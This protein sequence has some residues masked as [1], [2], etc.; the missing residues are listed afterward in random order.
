VRWTFERFRK[1]VS[2]DAGILSPKFIAPL[3]RAL[4]VTGEKER[5]RLELIWIGW[6]PSDEV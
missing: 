5:T 3:A 2:V 1:H 6:G 4:G